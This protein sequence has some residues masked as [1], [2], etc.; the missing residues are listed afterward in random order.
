MS[1]ALHHPAPADLAGLDA[2][3]TPTGD[4]YDEHD[5]HDAYDAHDTYD[6]HATYDA[7]DDAC[8]DARDDEVFRRGALLIARHG[9][10]Q[11]QGL[12]YV[13]A[14]HAPQA[15]SL[16]GALAWAATG[17]AESC[18]PR[19]RAA[20]ATVRR[21]LDPAG[22]AL[23]SDWEL[24]C[25]WNDAPARTRDETVALLLGSARS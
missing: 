5:A 21:R 7:R 11:G 12:L 18:G 10:C 4:P 6:A 16:V 17:D 20:L 24:L 14:P 9:W 23:F 22:S 15:A 2:L 25:A 19:V 8:D 1:T 13:G 3:G